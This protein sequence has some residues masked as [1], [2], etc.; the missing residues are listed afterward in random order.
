MYTRSCVCNTCTV[1][2]LA[3]VARG[4][5]PDEQQPSIGPM[6]REWA[7]VNGTLLLFRMFT[8]QSLMDHC[9][10]QRDLDVVELWAGVQSIVN[11][12]REDGF[13]AEGFDKNRIPGTTDMPGPRTEDILTP[14]GFHNAAKL[15]L[16]LRPGGLLH[17]A[18]V[19]SSFVGLDI[20]HTQRSKMDFRGNER[21]WSVEQGNLF[22][23]IAVFLTALAVM[24]GAHASFEN[25]TGSMIWS[26]VRMYC[27]VLD[28]FA[29]QIVPRCSYAA[30]PG[31]HFQKKYKFSA[32]GLW[33]KKLRSQ[34]R[35]PDGRHSDLVTRNEEGE[36][37]ATKELKSTQAYPSE[38]GQAIIDAW[39]GS[40]SPTQELIRIIAKAVWRNDT[41]LVP[42]S[43]LVAPPTTTACSSHLSS[44]ADSAKD[45]LA[46]KRRKGASGT[47]RQCTWRAFQ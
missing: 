14:D 17:V 5:F 25:P 41:P 15:V 19:C 44:G 13:R 20:M 37:R 11:A 8:L 47:C 21:F 38:L 32:S 7:M 23:H 30:G 29:T 26:Y 10:V 35:C 31:P 45:A 3:P 39:T 27:P 18:P 40:P 36:F 33:I 22:A 16:R 9:N 12:A 46:P 28:A 34:C 1:A 6:A 42:M 2:I 24:R 4:P 43:L